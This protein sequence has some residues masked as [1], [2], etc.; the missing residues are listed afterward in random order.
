MGLDK[1]NFSEYAERLV[2]LL[3]ASRAADAPKISLHHQA[4]PVYL[5]LEEAL[6]CG[7]IITELVSNSLKHAFSESQQG[8]VFV[9]IET[10]HGTD[11]MI[12]VT[13]DGVGL[14]AEF[15]I[16]GARSFGLQL[17]RNLVAELKGQIRVKNEHGA[18]FIVNFSEPASELR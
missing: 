7:M 14:P 1:I 18:S 6:A 17:V 15:A 10:L 11:I 12:E 2:L 8:E 13:D 16:E 9:T 3:F 4:E 5:R